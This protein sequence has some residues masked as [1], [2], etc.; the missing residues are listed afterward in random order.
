MHQSLTAFFLS[1]ET[2]VPNMK[3][4]L[5]FAYSIILAA[6]A[7]SCGS[8]DRSIDI[9]TVTVSTAAD[10]LDSLSAKDTVAVSDSLFSVMRI[11]FKDSVYDSSEDA[12]SSFTLTVDVPSGTDSLVTAINLWIA[13]QLNSRGTL[14]FTEEELSQLSDAY[15][16]QDGLKPG[17]RLCDSI[18]MVYN[19]DRYV[20]YERKGYEYTGG[21]HALPY[22]YGVTFDKATG[23]NISE[24][25]FKTTD[26]LGRLLKKHLLAQYAKNPKIDFEDLLFENMRKDFTLPVYPAWM[27]ADGVRFAYSTYEIA[28]YSVGI[29]TCTI[30]YSDIKKYLKR[31]D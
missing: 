4:L 13:R 10:T 20:S 17:T 15:L 19:T 26:G 29:P 3:K 14:S 2:S 11:H 28:P 30:P 24:D 21:A 31:K 9:D 12:T 27:V 1:S 22:Y 8:T 18:C 25:L 23:E 6:S 5:Y 16:R 7:V